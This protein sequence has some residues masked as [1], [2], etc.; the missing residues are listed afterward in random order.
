[1][2]V[3]LNTYSTNWHNFAHFSTNQPAITVFL[4]CLWYKYTSWY[5]I[6]RTLFNG[7]QVQVL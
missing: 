2:S 6:N 7:A 1:M 4:Y 3:Q 5:R